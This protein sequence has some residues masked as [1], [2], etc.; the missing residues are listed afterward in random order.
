MHA[1]DVLR[2]GQQTV[3]QAVAGLP[4]S[5][6]ETPG[7]VGVWSVREVIAHL[8]SFEQLLLDALSSLQ[9]SGPTPT[10]DR[11]IALGNAR[12]NDV[13]VADRQGMSSSQVWAELTTTA[14]TAQTLLA[15]IPVARRR[16]TG[17]LPWYGA[18]Y[19]LEDFIAYASYGHK[20]EHSAQIGAYRDRLETLNGS[21]SQR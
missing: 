12:F 13:E 16:E 21:D 9:N 10:L 7:V 4:E 2:Y 11:F 3:E 8:A 14:V 19:D 20:R 5:A 1:N 17:T 18:E 6:W 15:H